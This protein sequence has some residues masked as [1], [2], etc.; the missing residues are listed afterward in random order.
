MTSPGLH[1][2]AHALDLLRANLDQWQRALQIRFDEV[3][4]IYAPGEGVVHDQSSHPLSI[5]EAETR[6]YLHTLTAGDP[7]A[8]P[9]RA[10]IAK[11]L[12]DE[13]EEVIQQSHGV[14]A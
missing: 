11:A 1:P 4:P 14:A 12:A 13:L 8:G 2:L 9:T 3:A 10:R 6:L 5:E 7:D